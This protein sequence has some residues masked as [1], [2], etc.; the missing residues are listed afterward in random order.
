MDCKRSC[1]LLE[2]S[3]PFSCP[4]LRS[5]AGPVP[6]RLPRRGALLCVCGGS[7]DPLPRLPPPPAPAEGDALA[8]AGGREAE[9]S[10]PGSAP[11]CL[12]A[13]TAV[14]FVSLVC[15]VRACPCRPS[16]RLRDGE[17]RRGL[18]RRPRSQCPLRRAAGAPR[19]RARFT[20][21][22]PSSGPLSSAWA[23][24]R[25]VD[26]RVTEQRPRQQR[27]RRPWGPWRWRRGR[28]WW[29]SGSYAWRWAKR[30]GRSAGRA[31]AAGG[32]GERGSSE[33]C[34]T[35]TAAIRTWR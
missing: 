18:S 19:V 34:H 30:R 31:A 15:G 33:R 9:H 27:P 22:P 24:D 11:A 35:G 17:V 2:E 32:A 10:W 12:G 8:A 16:V 14:G 23:A 3:V 5:S 13:Q 28:S 26:S 25:S 7:W 1:V 4:S 21:L 6:Q 20:G 29:G